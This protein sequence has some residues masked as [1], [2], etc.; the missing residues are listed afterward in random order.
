MRDEGRIAE[1]AHPTRG[2]IEMLAAPIRVSD[3]EMTYR[4]APPLG[5]DAEDILKG[6]GYD[7]ARIERLRKAKVI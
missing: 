3:A 2:R 1:V 6:L 4:P 5:A 7:G